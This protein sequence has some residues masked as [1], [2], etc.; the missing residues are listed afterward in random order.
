MWY[1]NKGVQPQTRSL[2]TSVHLFFVDNQSL[3]PLNRARGQETSFWKIASIKI[4]AGSL[5]SG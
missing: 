1:T 4:I 2:A 3:P 5:Q